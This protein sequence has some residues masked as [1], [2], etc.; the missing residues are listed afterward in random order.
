MNQF[1]DANG[2][3]WTLTLT[4]GDIRRV[5]QECG[6]DLGEFLTK[7]ESFAEN[8]ADPEKLGAVL[9]VLCKKQAGDVTP[10]TFADG[11]DGPTIQ[12]AIKKLAGAIADFYQSPEMA[13]VIKAGVESRVEK[14]D[15]RNAI[16]L[17]KRL[18]SALEGL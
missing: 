2:K 5:R 3:V 12:S 15:K 1:T 10:E 11:F 9:W 14:L 8:I 4:L 17:S 6:V 18:G 13:K 16:E 7:P